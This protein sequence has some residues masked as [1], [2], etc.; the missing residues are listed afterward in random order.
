MKFQI[1][2]LSVA[3]CVHALGRTSS[4]N[5]AILGFGPPAAARQHALEAQFDSSLQ[6]ENLRDWM[7]R[8]SAHPHHVGS[9]S[10]KTNAQFIAEQF[11]SWGYDTQL[12]EFEVLFPTP[13]T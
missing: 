11:R 6:R 10:D 3:V 8:L 12:E 1:S 5:D 7:K 13:R 2:L 9:A 4:T